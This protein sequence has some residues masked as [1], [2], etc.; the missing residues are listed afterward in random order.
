MAMDKAHLF[1]LLGRDLEGCTAVAKVANAVAVEKLLNLHEH[2]IRIKDL[3]GAN[4]LLRANTCKGGKVEFTFGRFK[5]SVQDK[6]AWLADDLLGFE[7]RPNDHRLTGLLTGR[8]KKYEEA[9]KDLTEKCLDRAVTK[10]LEFWEISYSTHVSTNLGYP[11]V[12]FR[13]N[14]HGNIW[15]FG[16]VHL[17]CWNGKMTVL[18]EHEIVDGEPFVAVAQVHRS[19][20]KLKDMFIKDYLGA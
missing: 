2:G 10:E 15:S 4:D 17:N 14:H 1:T 18:Y 3:R 8:S 20:L 19:L 11:E 12:T 5:E 9:L 6:L 13:L 7:V 16:S